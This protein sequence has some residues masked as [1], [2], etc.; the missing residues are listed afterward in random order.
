MDGL[1]GVVD[2]DAVIALFQGP[3]SATLHERHIASV[4]KLCRQNAEGIAIRD[5]P[6][7]Q[8]VLQLTLQLLSSGKAEFLQTAVDLLKW[9]ATCL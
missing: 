3:N 8:H 7:M 4:E 5:L 9:V 1:S 2:L 6:K